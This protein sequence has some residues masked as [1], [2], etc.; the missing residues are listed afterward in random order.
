MARAG[1]GI[2]RQ[3]GPPAAALRRHRLA[4]QPGLAERVGPSGAHRAAR[5][6]CGEQVRR[7]RTVR[8]PHIAAHGHRGTAHAQRVRGVGERRG[9]R[10]PQCRG[11]P[12]GQRVEVLPGAGGQQQHLRAVRRLG[13]VAWG[14]L[15]QDHVHVRAADA[16]RA[17]PGAPGAEF[18][19]RPGGRPLDQVER[20]VVEAQFGV[21]AAG[22]GVRHQRGVLQHE[23]RLDQRGHARRRV[24]VADVRLH[25]ADPDPP[26]AERPLE[27]G[28]R[29]RRLDAVPERGGRAVRLQVLGV[30]R[31]ETGGRPGLHDR[32]GLLVDAGRGEPDLGG[33]VVGDGAAPDDRPDRVVVGERVGQPAQHD[34]THPVAGHGAAGPLVEG[35][36]AA[37]RGEDAALVVDV[38]PL[39]HRVHGDTAGQRGVALA[40]QQRLHR[41]VHRRQRG[42]A[43][44]LHRQAR[45]LQAQPVGD[46]GGEELAVGEDA[47]LERPDGR[48]E[49][50]IGLRRQHVLG[51]AAAHVHAGT[52]GAAQRVAAGVLQRGPGRLQEQPVLGVQGRRLGAVEAEH[53]RVE[54]VRVREVALGR[55]VVAAPDLLRVGA[56][57]DQLLL[58]EIGHR[59]EPAEQIAPVGVQV[60][61]AGEAAAHSDDRDRGVGCEGLGGACVLG[62]RVEPFR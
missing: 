49:L 9:A 48:G 34:H 19:L 44:R 11:Q 47:H 2:G 5:G 46:P 12:A 51:G 17:H 22:V 30:G 14:S 35:P 45:P 26:G 52:R 40:E 21:R 7:A 38:S 18:G 32:G 41:E 53:L 55:Y 33:T 1:E 29:R 60:G 36:A 8:C 62:H 56:V 15:L 20:R 10:R 28:G 58:G 61:G 13:A 25:R 54:A 50:R 43:G 59:A 39:V 31:V 23:H 57:G 4:R 3:S 6:Q 24:Q 16:D 37:V 27:R 42:R